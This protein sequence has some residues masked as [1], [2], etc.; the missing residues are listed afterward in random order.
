M[1]G[2]PIP[3]TIESVTP[4]WLT[5]VLHHVGVLPAGGRVAAMDIRQVGVGVGI[6]G[7]IHM[8]ALTY[9]GDAGSAPAT[10]VVKQASTF[11]A[12]FEQGV[13]LGTYVSE[14]RFYNELA[15]H[16][17]LRVPAS[18]HAEIADDG[19]F[20]IVM[21][22]LSGLR[23]LDQLEGMTIE[24]MRFATVEL[25]RLH[26]PFW[27]KV[28]ELEWIPSVIH[29]RIKGF[30]GVFPMFWEGTKKN[31]PDQLPPAAI[32]V[33]DA[34]AKYYWDAMAHLGTRPWTLLHMDYRC[35]NF[36]FDD[37]TPDAPVV[38]LD[39]QSLGRGPAAYDL[40]YFLGGSMTVED[41]RTHQDALLHAYHDELVRQGVS[42]YSYDDLFEDYRWASLVGPGA[43]VLVGGGLEMGNDRGTA[44]IASMVERHFALPVD[45]NAIE[46]IGG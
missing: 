37:A 41:R 24:Q 17:A 20:V 1:S 3:E 27:N 16:T 38:V 6:M 43:A 45:L 33:G 4:E 10:V 23:N 31:F 9:A 7:V 25:A 14:V 19:H 13:A 40:A 18:Y 11:P 2:L 15:T 34:V 46:L 35:D 36:L 44:L 42:G 12:N 21:E 26:G 8:V 28:S 39:W 29:D 30:A 5:N 32:A 22:D